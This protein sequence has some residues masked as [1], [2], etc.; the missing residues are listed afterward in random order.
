MTSSHRVFSQLTEVAG[1]P[2]TRTAASMLYSRY[3]YAASLIK[4]KKVLEIACGSGVGLGMASAVATQTIGGDI[5]LPLLRQ[6]QRHYQG[7]VPL[8]CFDAQE[9]PFADHSIDTV[10]LFEASYYV[11][12]FERA[13]DEITRVLKRPG[14]AIVVNANPDSSDFV[15]SPHSVKYYGADELR[16]AL[17]SRQFEVKIEGAFR[18]DAPGP[19]S[20][21][22]SALRKLA[23]RLNIIP[24]TLKGRAR[25]KKLIYRRLV[26]VPAEL[27]L[28][29]AERA[30]RVPWSSNEVDSYKIIYATALIGE[31][32]STS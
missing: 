32:S 1:T 29:F 2:L 12:D 4:D 5:E 25:I 6:A 16:N 10:L 26:S 27:V 3:D 7:R 19:K 24:K 30:E 22:L 21:V 14:I 9:I 8:V 11:P 31:N 13:L 17:E 20:L 15:P 18:A 28:G 23:V